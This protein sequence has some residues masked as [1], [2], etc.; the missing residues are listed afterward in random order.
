MDAQFFSD[1]RDLAEELCGD[2]G[3]SATF[4]RT[5]MVPDG[6]TGGVVPSGDP[7]TSTVNVAVLPVESGTGPAFDNRLEELSLAKKT[8]RYLIVPAKGMTLEPEALDEVSFEG[9]L[10]E[11]LGCTPI[12]PAGTPVIYGVGVVRL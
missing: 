6:S 2:F 7:L 5:T 1:M 8:L 9:H 12:N 3:Q 4:T 10:W 11:V